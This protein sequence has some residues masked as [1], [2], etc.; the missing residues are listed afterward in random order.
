MKGWWGKILRVDLTNN[1]VWVQE[2]SPE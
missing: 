1:K 2:Y